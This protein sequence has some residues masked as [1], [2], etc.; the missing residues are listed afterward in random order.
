[1]QPGK[2]GRNRFFA[3]AN[4]R[5]ARTDEKPSSRCKASVLKERQRRKRRLKT[6]LNKLRQSP[7][8]DKYPLGVGTGMRA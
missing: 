5:G 8:I 7:L 6:L 4:A 2:T 3:K 1:M